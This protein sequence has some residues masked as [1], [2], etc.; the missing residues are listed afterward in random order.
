M[1]QFPNLGV[2]HSGVPDAVVADRDEP[3]DCVRECLGVFTRVIVGQQP[4]AG[5]PKRCIHRTL[6]GLVQVRILACEV[7]GDEPGPLDV[8]GDVAPVLPVPFRLLL[9]DQP[10]R[11]RVEVDPV[12]VRIDVPEPG[13]GIHVLLELGDHVVRVERVEHR[14]GRPCVFTPGPSTRTVAIRPACK[15]LGVTAGGWIHVIERVL[16]RRL[17]CCVDVIVQGAALLIVLL[18]AERRECRA[19]HLFRTAVGVADERRQPLNGPAVSTG[20]EE[21]LHVLAFGRCPEEDWER[22]GL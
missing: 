15:L 3:E 21:E 22:Q 1:F 13:I 6:H 20:C 10:V 12:H 7:L 4:G 5:F 18:H 11:A 2:D 17:H 16:H 19:H 14:G 8:V 9:L